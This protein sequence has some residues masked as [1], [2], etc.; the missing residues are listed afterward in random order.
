M[1][2]CRLAV[3][4]FTPECRGNCLGASA[5]RSHRAAPRCLTWNVADD[6]RGPEA[7]ALRENGRLHPSG[8]SM[9]LIFGLAG[10]FL[11]IVAAVGAARAQSADCQ[12]LQQA[13]AAAGHGGGQNAQYGA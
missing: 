1:R 8:T 4:I 3:A 11:A 2:A 13:I 5:V 9:R 10:A 6:R 12:R 7:V